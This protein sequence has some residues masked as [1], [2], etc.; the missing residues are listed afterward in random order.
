LG[1]VAANIANAFRRDLK[2]AQ[3][4]V[5][6]GV[7]PSRAKAA[8]N[9]WNRWALFCISLHIDPSLEGVLEPIDIL[10]VYAHRYRT[11]ELAPSGR[12]V[13]S[14]TVEDSLRAVGQAFT[15]VGAKDPRLNDAGEMDFRLHRQLMS[16]SKGDPPPQRVK[17]IPIQVLFH[18]LHVAQASHCVANKA[19]ADMIILAFF[20]LLRPGEYTH[21]ASNENT[22]FRL[23]D[24]ELEIGRR[25]V[26]VTECSDEDLDAATFSKL[27]FTTQK[28][29]VRGEVIGLGLSGLPHFCPVRA[30][31]SRIKHLR[32]H[33]APPDTPLCAYYV[34]GTQKH[35]SAG[36]VTAALRASV[37][38]VGH[39]V[40]F[41]TKDI[42]ARSLRAAGAMALLCAH[43]DTDII[44]LVG[45]WRSDEMLTYL[46][47]QA[48]PVMRDF[49]S[50]MVVGGNYTLLPA[51]DNPIALRF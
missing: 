42:S 25:R 5:R 34:D 22:P 11:G 43:V 38:V 26:L 33:N 6:A 14:R 29:G 36:D 51:Q 46:H 44:R 20:Y 48:E 19:T 49:A 35:V 21:K 41:Q 27:T 47:V 15:S 1:T 9:H 17:P 7:V 13:K 24:V 8:D 10:Q 23:Q 45:R 3:E 37:T 28:N 31:V 32:Q 16:Y 18:V 50:M 40:G 39:L 12:P 30:V 4:A 2:L